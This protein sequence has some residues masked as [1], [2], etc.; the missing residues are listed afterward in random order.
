MIENI[1]I[2]EKYSGVIAMTIVWF[3]LIL[4]P[5]TQKDLGYSKETISMLSTKRKGVLRSV[6]FSLFVG[7]FFQMLF[8]LYIQ[9]SF[10]V[11]TLSFGSLLYISMGV[12]TLL[13][14]IYTAK[15]TPSFIF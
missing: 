6:T 10:L 4:Y 8:L 9:K 5:Y 13:V 2:L 12:A 14:A 7:G 1:S 15:N 3:V 11:N